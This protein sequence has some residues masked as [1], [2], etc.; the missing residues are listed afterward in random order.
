MRRKRQRRSYAT[1]Q[2]DEL[3]RVDRGMAG[4]LCGFG[5]AVRSLLIGVNPKCG[6]GV[7]L[8][9]FRFQNI[10]V[11]K[12]KT[13]FYRQRRRFLITIAR[14]WRHRM[15]HLGFGAFHRARIRFIQIFWLRNAYSD[16]G[17]YG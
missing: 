7:T 5:H 1:P 12:C 6:A 3:N 17:Y 4:T 16:W 14:R 10:E 9:L 15:V 8:R 13:G 11:I 2:P